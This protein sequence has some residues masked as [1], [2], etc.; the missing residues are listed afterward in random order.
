[1]KDVFQFVDLSAQFALSWSLGIGLFFLSLDGLVR[2]PHLASRL[3]GHTFMESTLYQQHKTVSE[4]E[5]EINLFSQ[6]ISRYAPCTYFRVRPWY[7]NVN[8][9]LGV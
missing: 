9:W 7:L 1:V 3:Y 8:P 2:C 4:I 6:T 5:V